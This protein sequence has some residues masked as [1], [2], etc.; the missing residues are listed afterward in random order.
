MTSRLPARL[1][2]RMAVVTGAAS[3]IGR[4]IAVRL[5]GEGATVLGIDRDAAGLASAQ[6]QTTPPE[7]LVPMT[8]DV[9]DPALPERIHNWLR[10]HGRVLDIL[11]NNAGIGGGGKATETSDADWAR[12]LDANLTSVFRLSRF[13]VERMKGR[14]GV[15]LNI[16]SVYATV[17]ATR[18]AA[19]TSTKAAIAGLT[20]QMATDYGREGIRVV[21]IA[22]GLIETPMT[23]ERNRS[24]PWRRRI[25]IDQCP[26]HRAGT[27]EEVAAAAAFLVSGDA[28]FINGEILRVDGGWAMGR[29]P[30]ASAEDG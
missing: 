15:I 8:G 21:A 14:G 18:S 9:T 16:A 2:D 22:P 30:P 23:A 12:Y 27:P 7:R 24:D 26:L 5:A 29:Y 19:Y 17:G 11:V 10:Q 13:A 6:A 28:S 3:G 4:A 1:E 20:R 25:L